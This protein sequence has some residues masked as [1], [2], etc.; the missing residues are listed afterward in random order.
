MAV[1]W[2]TGSSGN[3]PISANQSLDRIDFAI[4]TENTPP[5]L[6]SNRLDLNFDQDLTNETRDCDTS[7]DGDFPATKLNYYRRAHTRHMVTRV[8]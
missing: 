4:N 3:G 5:R 1:R 2:I 8:V 7:E 6:A